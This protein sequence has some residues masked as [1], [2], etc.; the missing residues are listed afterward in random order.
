MKNPTPLLEQFVEAFHRLDTLNVSRS[1]SF[2]GDIEPLLV[3]PW[4]PYGLADWRPHRIE[5]SAAAMDAFHHQ[6][7]G[8]LPP[9]YDELVQTYAWWMVDLETFRLLPN[10]PP[11]PASVGREIVADP[12]LFRVLSAGGFVQ[13]GRGPDVDYDPVCFDLRNCGAD[14]DCRVVKFD[15]EDILIRETLSIVD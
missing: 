10:L 3:E 12:V 1:M 5:T 4:D 11:V 6:V 14:G 2:G 8:P 13:F 15:H 7:G 9:M